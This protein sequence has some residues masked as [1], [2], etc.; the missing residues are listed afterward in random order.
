MLLNSWIYLRRE[1][2][3]LRLFFM[4]NI[5]FNDYV[6]L[7]EIFQYFYLELFRMIYILIKIVIKF[8]YFIKQK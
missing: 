5:F 2:A 6:S 8:Y 1:I 3:E 4:R 7:F